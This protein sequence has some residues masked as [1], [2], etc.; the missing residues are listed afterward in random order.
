MRSTWLLMLPFAAVLAC[1]SEKGESRT[2]GDTGS[3]T[4]DS[5]G[6]A[7][8][9]STD[10]GT[11]TDATTATPTGG[12]TDETTATPTGGDTDAAFTPTAGA[13]TLEAGERGGTC[14]PNNLIS[15]ST[16]F[17]EANIVL[18]DGGFTIELLDA[19]DDPRILTCALTGPAF[20]CTGPSEQKFMQTN[21]DA[22]ASMQFSAAGTWT[23]ESTLE[24]TITGAL[25]CTGDTAACDQ[26]AT[27]WELE[28]PCEMTQ[29]HTG[30]L[31]D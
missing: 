11:D 12:D 17:F 25:A 3:A 14:D 30:A 16:T 26:A 19:F 27:D 7:T 1:S 5:T 4:D 15:G 10:P 23:S 21:P 31:S 24:L 2:D 8:D 28:M 20:T 9:V 29:L 6:P 18:A 22:T 13:Y